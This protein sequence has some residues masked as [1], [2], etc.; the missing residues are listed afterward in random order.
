MSDSGSSFADNLPLPVYAFTK[1]ATESI[2]KK[3]GMEPDD[4][5]VLGICTGA[6]ASFLTAITTGIP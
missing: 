3:C 1:D 6:A 2:A 5:R 4:A